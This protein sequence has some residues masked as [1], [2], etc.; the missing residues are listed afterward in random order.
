MKDVKSRILS[1]FLLVTFANHSVAKQFLQ[2][3]CTELTTY[4]AERTHSFYSKGGY[5]SYH[6]HPNYRDTGETYARLFKNV[7]KMYEGDRYISY[8]CPNNI[9][10]TKTVTYKMDKSDMTVDIGKQ[11][12]CR[13]VGIYEKYTSMKFEDYIEWSTDNIIDQALAEMPKDH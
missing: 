11:S 7:C 1:L 9:T 13:K 3:K 10:D 5:V 12:N 4:N 2:Y 8:V 6:N